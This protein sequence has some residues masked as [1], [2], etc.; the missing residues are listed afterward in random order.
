MVRVRLSKQRPEA[1]LHH[2][3]IRGFTRLAGEIEDLERPRHRVVPRFQLDERCR[4]ATHDRRDELLVD[5]TTPQ[6]RTPERIEHRF[7]D[8][9]REACGAVERPQRELNRLTAIEIEVEDQVLAVGNETVSAPKEADL[10]DLVAMSNSGL[11]DPAARSEILQQPDETFSQIALDRRCRLS[12]EPGKEYATRSG[13]R[14]DRKITG[15]ERD[16]PGGRNRT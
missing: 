10:V 15:S 5:R 9:Q 6:Q 12:Q 2:S 4:S 1:A 11:R 13:G 7:T 16:P 3:S 14:V 8:L